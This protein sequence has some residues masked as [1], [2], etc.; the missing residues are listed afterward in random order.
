MKINIKITNKERENA[1]KTSQTIDAIKMCSSKQNIAAKKWT[2]EVP[3]KVKLM[4]VYSK[5]AEFLQI[6]ET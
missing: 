4:K 2:C 1:L 3:F 6:N 5:E